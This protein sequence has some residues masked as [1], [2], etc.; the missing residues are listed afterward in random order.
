[1]FDLFG[2]LVSFWIL[3]VGDIVKFW[4]DCDFSVV[5]ILTSRTRINS[6]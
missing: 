3:K 2:L 6:T 1:M 5:K 4:L